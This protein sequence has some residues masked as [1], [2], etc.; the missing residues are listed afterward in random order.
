[1]ITA[2]TACPPVALKVSRHSEPALQ[3]YCCSEL[4]LVV[5][6]GSRGR[7]GAMSATTL[8]E[9]ILYVA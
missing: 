7:S 1:M 5:E 4:L 6:V 9:E 2:N 8:N 3:S